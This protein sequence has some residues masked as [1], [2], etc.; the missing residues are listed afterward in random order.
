MK[1]SH[2]FGGTV[3]TNISHILNTC[4][5]TGYAKQPLTPRVY[6]HFLASSIHLSVH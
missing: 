5:L 6:S 4:D 1:N 2:E 3:S